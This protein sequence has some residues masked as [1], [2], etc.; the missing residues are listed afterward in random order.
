MHD[1]T[2][3]L[4][5][6]V[7]IKAGPPKARVPEIAGVPVRTVHRVRAETEARS[8][9]ADGTGGMTVPEASHGQAEAGPPCGPG[10]LPRP[11]TTVSWWRPS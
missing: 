5:I 2:E 7:S 6:E 11:R 9:I 3:R 1:A 10:G 4:E 8:V